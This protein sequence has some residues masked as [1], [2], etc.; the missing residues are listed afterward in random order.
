MKKLLI[1]ATLLACSTAALAEGPYI[2][3]TIGSARSK[4]DCAGTDSCNNNST[5]VKGF[6]GYSFNDMFSMEGT[7]YDLGKASASVSGANVDLKTTGYGL[8][9]LVAVPFNKDFSGFAALGINRMKSKA[10]VNSGSF[11]GSTDS[12][13][14]K[15]SV[16]VGVDYAL[17]PMLKVRGEVE[18]M[19]VDAPASSGSY[20]IST[21]SVG[22]KYQ[23]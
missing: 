2:G 7:Y 23:F 20:N 19:R 11:S 17:S 18:S 14:T 10:S 12:T 1:A 21:V 6:V 16:A 3:G 13:S 8:R 9:G 22:L 15:P 5:A 4:L